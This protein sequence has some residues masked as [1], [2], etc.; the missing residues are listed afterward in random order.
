LSGGFVLVT[1]ASMGLGAERE[2]PRLIR[3]GLETPLP[4]L[5]FYL[6]MHKDLRKVP[7]IRGVALA[8]QEVFAE[9]LAAQADAEAQA[10]QDRPRPKTR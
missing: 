1:G 6:T 8:L 5:R 2:H 10:R 3:V 4:G 7:R 9:Y